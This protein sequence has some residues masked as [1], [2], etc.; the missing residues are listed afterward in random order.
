MLAVVLAFAQ[1]A[2]RAFWNARPASRFTRGVVHAVHAPRTSHV[3]PCIPPCASITQSA[4]RRALRCTAR[5]CVAR[6]VLPAAPLGS[7][8]K[9]LSSKSYDIT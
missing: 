9:N 1:V 5:R 6:L 2:L 8:A 3:T 4:D 7:V